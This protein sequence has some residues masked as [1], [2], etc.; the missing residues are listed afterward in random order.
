M[1]RNLLA[2]IGLIAI[3]VATFY[4]LQTQDWGRD[5]TS[6]VTGLVSPAGPDAQ[7]APEETTAALANVQ[8]EAKATM[9]AGKRIELT[10]KLSRPGKPVYVDRVE[11][12]FLKDDGA[13]WRK[14]D[15]ETGQALE[16]LA[17]DRRFPLEPEASF[18]GVCF[19]I[20]ESKQSPRVQRGFLFMNKGDGERTEMTATSREQRQTLGISCFLE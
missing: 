5:V 4:A 15:F 2:A 8:A 3:A 10:S 9:V 20:A 17:F 12:I 16:T 18:F 6:S 13:I 19:T 14:I 11:I 7:T 1:L